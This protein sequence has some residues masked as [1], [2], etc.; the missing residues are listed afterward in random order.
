VASI[1]LVEDEKLIRWGFRRALEARGHVVDEAACLEQAENHLRDHRPDILILD[2]RLPDGNGVDFMLEQ[3]AALSESLVIVIT[4]SGAIDT[5]VRAMKAGAMD[6]L[7]K[8]LAEEEMLAAVD[9]AT[10]RLSERNAV[11]RT[12]RDGERAIERTVVA[13][14][15]GMKGILELA[16]I[17]AASPAA[18]VLVS[19]ETGTGKEVVARFIHARSARSSHPTLAL[20]CAALPENLVESE[21]FGHE[22]GAF[23]DAKSARKGIFELGDGGTIVLD[24]VGELPMPLQAKLL[25]FLEERTFRR[26][27]GTREIRVDVR[28]VAL[29]NRDLEA[30]TKVNEFRA[31][32]FF[33]LNVFPIHIPPLRERPEDI[34]PLAEHFVGLFG[35]LCGKTFSGISP[36]LAEALL[37]HQWP[38]NVRELRNLMERATILESGGVVTG[39]H[40]PL[41]RPAETATPP[42]AREPF[43]GE[44][45]PL[46]EAEFILVERAMRLCNGNQSKAGRVLGVTRDQ[47]RYRVK[48]YVDEGRWKLE[49]PEEDPAA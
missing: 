22:K 41:S 15:F 9:Q 11:E 46:D 16:A 27:G 37:R 18:T 31:D 19:G 44:V 17:V 32:L 33:R 42:A 20:N 3:K 45:L 1:L 4:A 49:T 28:V 48:R 8:P 6:F 5:A 36:E 39:R 47:V 14:S 30:A 7:S 40:L 23:T 25:R 34:V 26:V 38:G 29:S 10:E 24:E 12:R 35:P 21:L 13:K 2:V 43:G